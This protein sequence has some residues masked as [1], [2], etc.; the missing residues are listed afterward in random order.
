MSTTHLMRRR[1]LVTPT[2]SHW[3]QFAP[4][5]DTDGVRVDAEVDR[6]TNTITLTSSGIREVSVFFCDELVD[7]SKPVTVIANGVTSKNTFPRSVNT[8]L[9]FLAQ[10]KNDAGRSFVAT[11]QFHLPAVARAESDDSGAPK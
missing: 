11:K 9:K 10:G 7:M 6:E 4:V 2:V 3:I 1:A 8:F 5:S